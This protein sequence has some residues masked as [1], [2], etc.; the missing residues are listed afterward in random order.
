[1]NKNINFTFY[2]LLINVLLNIALNVN[3]FLHS[4]KYYTSGTSQMAFC[5]FALLNIKAYNPVEKAA[6]IPARERERRGTLKFK[7]YTASA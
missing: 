6:S 2:Y 3:N 5:S 4:T 7:A 1:M